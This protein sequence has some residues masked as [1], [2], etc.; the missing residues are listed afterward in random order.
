MR[1]I[2]KF[3]FSFLFNPEKAIISTIE[4]KKDK[5]TGRKKKCSSFGDKN[6]ISFSESQIAAGRNY[7]YLISDPFLSL[8]VTF[9]FNYFCH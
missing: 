5:F 4:D 9:L 8:L 2:G 6:S 7:L 1:S 3:L